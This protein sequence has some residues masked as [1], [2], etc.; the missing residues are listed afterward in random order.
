LI[1]APSFVFFVY[2]CC[3]KY[4]C[5][6]WGET[7]AFL[8]FFQTPHFDAETFWWLPRWSTRALVVYAV[9][10]A[11]QF[12]LAVFLPGP[13]DS[14]QLTPAGHILK[15]KCNGWRAFFVTHIALYVVVF[16]LKWVPASLLYH[17]WGG[18]L[19]VANLYGYVLTLFS[20]IK[21]H[22]APSHPDDCKFSGSVLYDFFMGVE[23]NPRFGDW[24]DF[25]LFHNGRPGI[26]AWSVIILSFAGAQYEK[27][28][29]VTNSMVA[30]YL[31]QVTYILDFFWNEGWYL[32]TIDIAHDHF[33]FYLAWGD[34][35][36]LPW[37]Y[38]L[39]AFFLVVH[40][41]DLPIWAFT[42]VLCLGGAGYF[43]FRS[44]NDQKDKF[45]KTPNNPIWGKPPRY[46]EAKFQT[47]DGSTRT[48]TLL[49]SGFWGLSRHFNY[50]GDLMMSL[51]FCLT[52]GLTHI[53]PY[54][55]IIYMTMLLVH[56]VV[57]DDARCRQKYGKY[58]ED[59][60]RLV[61]WRILP[62]VF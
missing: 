18:L 12:T 13:V 27:Y 61:P 14:G 19:L 5:S 40:P 52:C 31:L 37:L 41:V 22:V 21:A 24:L 17:E 15:Y 62:Y 20:Y 56:R 29:Y 49:A 35:V 53:L 1:F 26:I 60:C 33:G 55:Y 58:W 34:C 39:Q 48:S 16:Q 23:L 51:S 8:G 45:R 50:V 57:R 9:W 10:L 6:L 36:W 25:K 38:P 7:T 2:T 54:F 44:V 46:I 42:A 32:R 30:L 59:Y 47:G 3:N 28:G 43:I 4:S 11:F